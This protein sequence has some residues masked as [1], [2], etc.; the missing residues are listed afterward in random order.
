MLSPAEYLQDDMDRALDEGSEPEDDTCE[1]PPDTE[2]RFAS[3]GYYR[4]KIGYDE[5][6]ADDS[7]D[8]EF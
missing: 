2:S 6:R 8:V 3:D 4:R 5:S 1:I 7:A